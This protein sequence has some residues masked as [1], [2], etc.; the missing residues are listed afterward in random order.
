MFHVSGDCNP[1]HNLPCQ[2]EL[3]L[4]TGILFLIGIGAA[5][6]AYF[7]ASYR[8]AAIILMWLPIMLLPAALSNEGVPHAL[9]SIGAIP[10]VILLAT[11]GAAW[12]LEKLRHPAATWALIAILAGFGAHDLYRYFGVW[13]N[14]PAVH[15]AFNANIAD[16]AAYLNALPPETPRYVIA[17][18]AAATAPADPGQPD[19]RYALDLQSLIFL[20]R[21]HPQP[22]YLRVQEFF[23][24]DFPPGSVVAP[25]LGDT[26]VLDAL[27]NRGI[28]FEEQRNG[29]AIAAR[30][31]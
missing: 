21:G 3:N 4:P 23:T 15:D 22:N 20:V 24:A 8:P 14:S 18:E 7:K 16:L 10:A 5:A 2:P 17:N 28:E 19:R 1:R 6:L 12:S 26:R 11:F 25:L 13:A 29:A 31:R 27:R 9:R 30:I